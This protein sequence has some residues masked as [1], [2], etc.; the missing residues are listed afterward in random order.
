METRWCYGRPTGNGNL[1]IALQ[2]KEWFGEAK[3]PTRGC[4]E[5]EELLLWFILERAGKGSF[6]LFGWRL[7][8]LRMTEF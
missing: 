8:S 1:A 7:T 4:S 6:D 3:Q 2:R 5:A